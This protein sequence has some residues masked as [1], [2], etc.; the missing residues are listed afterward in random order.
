MLTEKTLGKN[1]KKSTLGEKSHV[2]SGILRET[3]YS[4]GFLEHQ[5]EFFNYIP[6][7]NES[8]CHMPRIPEIL[9]IS[10][11]QKNI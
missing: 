2:Q 3:Y 7:V 4:K 11:R 1:K 8:S 5:L 6:H 10:L 9:Q